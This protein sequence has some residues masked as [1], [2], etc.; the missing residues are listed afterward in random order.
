MPLVTVLGRMA[1]EESLAVSE[2]QKDLLPT[3][4]EPLP[5]KSLRPE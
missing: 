4:R 3:S 1:Y 5:L 2:R